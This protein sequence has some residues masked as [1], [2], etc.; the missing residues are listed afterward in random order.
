MDIS[1]TWGSLLF[2]LWI[3]RYVDKPIGLLPFILLQYI[4]F[5][6][7]EPVLRP[8]ALSVPVALTVEKSL[9]EG[10]VAHGAAKFV[11]G[12][13]SHRNSPPF[14]FATPTTSP[15]PGSLSLEATEHD[16]A[17]ASPSRPPPSRLD[18]LGSHPP[19]LRAPPGFSCPSTH[20][21]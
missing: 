6:S 5:G 18:A 8:L 2:S 20:L 10:H 4:N 1:P 13:G 15:S 12:F 21:F 9:Q 11:G 14:I 7:P 17:D 16:T 3:P 19:R